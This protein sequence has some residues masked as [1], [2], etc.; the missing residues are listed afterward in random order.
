[1]SIDRIQAIKQR[2]QTLKPHSL[3]II[4]DSD[5]HVGHAS[6]G[7]AGHFTVRIASESFNGKTR[8]RQHQMVYACLQD[9]MPEHIHAL[10]IHTETV[11]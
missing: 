7:G 2:L 11:D 4:D 10:S 8:I 5:Q 9:M 1:M 6:A 3:E